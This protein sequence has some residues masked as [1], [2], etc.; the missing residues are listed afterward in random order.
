MKRAGR[1]AWRSARTLAGL[2]E[3]VIA[4]WRTSRKL[5]T[6]ALVP[7]VP[8]AARLLALA[9]LLAG[10]AFPLRASTPGPA[11]PACPAG[12]HLTTDQVGLPE[13]AR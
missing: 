13:C 10:A 6:A 11:V 4:S 5:I 9:V 8:A 1:R 2:G 3:L 7:N 12:Q